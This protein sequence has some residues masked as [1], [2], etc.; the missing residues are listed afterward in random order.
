L[1]IGPSFI[2]PPLPSCRG[3]SPSEAA[4]SPARRKAAGST[5]IAAMALD[6]IGP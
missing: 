3:T 4:K 6:R 5:T 1:L 2:L